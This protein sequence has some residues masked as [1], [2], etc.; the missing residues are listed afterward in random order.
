MAHLWLTNGANK[1][2]S[3]LDKTLVIVERPGCL[4]TIL[5]PGIRYERHGL[6]NNYRLTVCMLQIIICFRVLNSNQFRFVGQKC[7]RMGGTVAILFMYA[8]AVEL[9]VFIRTLQFRKL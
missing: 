3:G 9:S 5:F 1:S 8:N 7:L 2:I 6:L 4:K